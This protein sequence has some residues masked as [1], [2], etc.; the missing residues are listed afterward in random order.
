ME[1]E[2]ML[3]PCCR[4]PMEAGYVIADPLCSILWFSESGKLP[5]LEEQC[6]GN[7]NAVILAR[8]GQSATDTPWKRP[9]TTVRAYICKHCRKCVI[10]YSRREAN[11]SA[12]DK[13]ERGS[14]GEKVVSISEKT[15]R[16]LFCNE[17]ADAGYLLQ[18]SFTVL[19]PFYEIIWYSEKGSLPLV[20]DGFEYDPNAAV[21]SRQF[22]QAEGTP[23][24]RPIATARA[25]I[26][27][28][29]KKCL[30]DYDTGAEV[31]NTDVAA[32]RWN[33]Y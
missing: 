32:Q 14:D 8:Q 10:D 28:S 31:V 3:C 20:S 9:M 21:L 13:R 16:C 22:E 33:R 29:C 4:E 11:T 1:K 27:K 6:L 19:N 26:C 7:P 2:T 15:P 30:V 17:A 12:D 24:K 23:W 25:Y 5:L 18:A